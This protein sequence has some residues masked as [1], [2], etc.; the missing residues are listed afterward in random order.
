MEMQKTNNASEDKTTVQRSKLGKLIYEKRMEKGWSF[1]QAAQFMGA[2]HSHL[3]ALEIG[4]DTRGTQLIAPT[5]PTLQKLSA[6]YEIDIE[7]LLD[8]TG[9]NTVRS[10]IEENKN[11]I[12]TELNIKFL[13][14]FS[15]LFSTLSE[16]TGLNVKELEL[17]S[18]VSR[19]RLEEFLRI[20]HLV[21]TKSE[22]LKLLAEFNITT[23][24]IYSIAP[25]LLVTPSYLA[26]YVNDPNRHSSKMPKLKEIEDFIQQS[27]LMHDGMPL[28]DDDKDKLANIIAAMFVNAQNETV[29][30]EIEQRRKKLKDQQ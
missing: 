15:T 27:N 7:V 24:E 25:S 20:D 29:K 10:T 18:R 2:S 14:R 26:G 12:N 5:Y 4:H 3:R 9:I 22:G 28:Q 6:L 16:K 13:D 30:K 23:E 8:A 11:E 21:K 1:R 17:E 19:Q